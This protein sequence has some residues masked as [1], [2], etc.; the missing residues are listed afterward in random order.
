M[1]VLLW[2]HESENRHKALYPQQKTNNLVWRFSCR[3]PFAF[4]VRHVVTLRFFLWEVVVVFLLKVPVS[5]YLEIV[6]V[7]NVLTFSC[8]CVPA[9][10]GGWVGVQ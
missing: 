5:M 3:N 9:F 10:E 2:V 1:S 7:W 8:V 4:R 6:N